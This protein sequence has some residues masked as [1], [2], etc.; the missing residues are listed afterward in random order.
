MKVGVS[1]CEIFLFVSV[2]CENTL[3]DWIRQ[4]M[5]LFEK[6]QDTFLVSLKT[7]AFLYSHFN[8]AHDFI[9]IN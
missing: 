9:Y 2:L 3:S 1:L 6:C 5:F 8:D 7:A 4:T